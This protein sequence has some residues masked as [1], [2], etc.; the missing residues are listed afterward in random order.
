MTPFCP[1]A[2]EAL[3][4]LLLKTKVQIFKV[5]L[6]SDHYPTVNVATELL[7]T[8]LQVPVA[9]LPS[10]EKLISLPLVVSIL[11]MY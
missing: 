8:L 5:P 10:T 4:S 3:I 6:L 9:I 11:P 7:W 2:I 1:L